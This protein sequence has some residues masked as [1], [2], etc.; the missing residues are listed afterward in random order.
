MLS[1]F[2][3]PGGAMRMRPEPGEAAIRWPWRA[4]RGR[5]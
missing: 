3:I 1:G 5:L 2:R 4:I